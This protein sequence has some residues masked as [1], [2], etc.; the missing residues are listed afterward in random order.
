[1]IWRYSSCHHPIE[2]EVQHGEIHKVYVPNKF[3]DC[4]LK[5]SQGVE[6]CAVDNCLCKHIGELNDN[7][8]TGKHELTLR[9]PMFCSK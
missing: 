4:P 6:N 5:R 8:H 3:E 9:N 2:G 7:L 1:M